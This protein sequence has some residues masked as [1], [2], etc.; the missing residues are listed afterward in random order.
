MNRLN[1]TL[2]FVVCALCSLASEAAESPADSIS[3][4]ILDHSSPVP[5][6]NSSAWL[7]PAL[8]QWQWSSSLS[9]VAVGFNHHKQSQ[10]VNPQQGTGGQDWYFKADSYMKHRTSTLWG[11]ASY[12]NGRIRNKQ[13]CEAVDL[14]LIYPYYPADGR[15]GSLNME[16]YAFSGGYADHTDSWAWGASIGYTAGL[17]YRPVDPR[18]KDVTGNLQIAAGGARTIG[19]YRLG[20]GLEFMKYKQ[21]VSISFVSEMGVDKI[22]HTTGMG[23]HYVRFAGNG[24]TTYYNGYRYGASLSLLPTS[25]QGFTA[26]AAVSRFSFNSILSDLNK[27]PL[28]GAWHNEFLL[29]AGYITSNWGV[30]AKFNIY[31]RHGHENIFGD[32]TGSI[33][34]QIGSSDTYADNAYT[35]AVNGAWQRFLSPSVRIHASGEIAY[36]HRCEAYFAPGRQSITNRAGGKVA[37]GVSAL[38]PHQWTVQIDMA[39]G[40]QAPVASNDLI[41]RET[42]SA[43]SVPPLIDI[44]RTRHSFAAAHTNTVSASVAISRAIAHKYAIRLSGLHYFT[45]YS[46]LAHERRSQ[47]AI[48]FLF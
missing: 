12:S 24:A 36:S 16:Q 39:Y 20:L 33:Y 29:N 5:E 28:C 48:S 9:T 10:A 7:N 44:E 41:L 4:R 6:L 25:L 18:P 45:T 34:P 8:K 2:I 15:G 27:L 21:S 14:D 3:L 30:T 35:T 43:S 22:Y 11:N 13:W 32:A 40:G 17:Y 26:T 46:G 1:H 19:N 37:A 38:L 23:T 42:T 31:K 47:A